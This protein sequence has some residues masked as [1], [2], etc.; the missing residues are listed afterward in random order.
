MKAPSKPETKPSTGGLSAARAMCRFAFP[1]KNVDDPT[2]ILAIRNLAL[3]IDQHT[4]P[5]QAAVKELVEAAKALYE[6]RDQ[7]T[8]RRLLSALKPFGGE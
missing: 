4:K 3:E 7:H 6:Y 8:S 1:S 2:L 5:N